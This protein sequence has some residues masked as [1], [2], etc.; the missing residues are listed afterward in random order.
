LEG[1]FALSGV[2]EAE[3]GEELQTIGINAFQGSKLTCSKAVIMVE[4]I[5]SLMTVPF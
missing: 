5:P 4:L 3:F 1:A 2:E